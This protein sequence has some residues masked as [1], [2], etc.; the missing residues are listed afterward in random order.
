[1]LRTGRKA[2]RNILKNKK[3]FTAENSFLNRQICQFQ[4]SI[5]MTNLHIF[6]LLKTLENF[7]SFTSALIPVIEGLMCLDWG[8]RGEQRR[9]GGGSVTLRLITPSHGRSVTSQ[10]H[11]RQITSQALQTSLGTW[12]ESKKSV[13]VRITNFNNFSTQ[14]LFFLP[15]ALLTFTPT[16]QVDIFSFNSFQGQKSDGFLSEPHHHLSDKTG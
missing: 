13:Y 4:E 5:R 12:V 1:M 15:Q 9:G 3:V 11:H 16:T 6:Y 10:S 8:E 2:G 14:V 7:P